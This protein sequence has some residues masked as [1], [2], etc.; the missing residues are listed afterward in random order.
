MDKKWKEKVEGQVYWTCCETDWRRGLYDEGTDLTRYRRQ[1]HGGEKKAYLRPRTSSGRPVPVKL[2]LIEEGEQGTVEDCAWC[3]PM[4][5][6]GKPEPEGSTRGPLYLYVHRDDCQ[7]I[8]DS[9]REREREE[10]D[11]VPTDN[12]DEDC[13]PITDI[14]ESILRDLHT[15]DKF[16]LDVCRE[17]GMMQCSCDGRR[18]CFKATRLPQPF[19]L[20]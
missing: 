14:T 5:D 16:F 18:L 2:S 8:I 20:Y 15:V 19:I 7:V 12:E 9:L 17:G 4:G 11:A 1:I 10:Q 6:H 13:T 3:T